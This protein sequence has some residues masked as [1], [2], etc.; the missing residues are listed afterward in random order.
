MKLI[1]L[2]GVSF[3]YGSQLSTVLL[4]I[5]L[6]IGVGQC[7]CVSGPTG[8]GKSSLLNLLAGV[9]NRPHEGEIWRF[10][11]LVTGLVTQDPQKQLLRKTVGAEI[12]FALEAFGIPA[13]QILSKVQ[14]ALRRAGLYLRLDTQL[15]T[16]SVGQTYRL[17]IAAQ[18]ACEPHL[19]LLDEPWAQL[20]DHGV[21]ELLVV[22]GNLL[23]EGMA[24]VLVEH[25]SL[26]FAGIIQHYW[27]LGAGKL[28]EGIYTVSEAA[29]IE[30]STWRDQAKF[31]H[32]GKV[33]INA[34][35]FEFGF[36]GC[37]VLFTC[38]QGFKLKAGEIV[39]LVGENGSGKTGLL[40]GLAGVLN[41]KQRLPI[42]VLGR[43]PKLGVYGADLGLL[44]QR[45]SRQLFEISVL[46]EMQFSLTRFKLPKE[47][48]AQML[49]ELGLSDLAELPP[50]K[51]SH[52]QQHLI[53][54]A[55]L[56]CLQPKVLLLDDPL[57]GMDKHYYDKAWY[58]LQYLSSQGCAILLSSHRC[59]THSAVSWQLSLHHGLLAEGV[60]E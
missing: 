58:L 60:I 12:S 53:A 48:A 4:D 52:G 23:Q 28:S 21:S 14:L 2:E 43:R 44:I 3:N 8:S 57:A 29:Q 31:E 10:P 5:N 16:L 33:L 25:N 30:M 47:R 46:A 45:P 35:S 24:L 40:K 15:N 32:T 37:P 34:E 11:K 9:L 55:S 6:T 1:T 17:M 41:L 42:K 56:A 19:L 13:E 39:T 18:L 36:D 51:L 22:L 54:L 20:D 27:Q 49:E 50:Y 26:A 59:I 38:P 7:H